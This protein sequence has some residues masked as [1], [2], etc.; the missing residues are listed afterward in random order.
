MLSKHFL[1][2]AKIR[3]INNNCSLGSLICIRLK[4][5]SPPNMSKLETKVRR[6]F[7]KECSE[8]A[9][10]SRYLTASESSRSKK[11]RTLKC[12]KRMR[13]LSSCKA[14]WTILR[15]TSCQKL[16][17]TC[18]RKN[19]SYLQSRVSIFHACKT[20]PILRVS[21]SWPKAWVVCRTYTKSCRPWPRRPKPKRQATFNSKRM[22][23]RS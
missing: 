4:R 18:L 15:P 7:C 14:Y 22:K 11:A 19:Q 16:S 8:H 17:K 1:K 12:T 5:Q 10:I 9:D 3:S 23:S 6:R 2:N 21:P 20:S 13:K